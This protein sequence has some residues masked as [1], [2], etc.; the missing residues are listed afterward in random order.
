MELKIKRGQ[1]DA[2]LINTSMR[3]SVDARAVFTDEERK[4]IK[5][6]DLGKLLVY[7][8]EKAKAA[9]LGMQIVRDGTVKGDMRSI[10]LIAVAAMNI[11]IRVRDLEDGKSVE[12]KSLDEVLGAEEAFIEGCKN[13]QAYLDT[14]ATFDGRETIMSFTSAPR[15]DGGT[16]EAY[17]TSDRTAASLG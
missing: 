16:T 8:S 12:C 3:F 4:S 17:L 13:L 2:G 9:A 10:G 1:R 5:K 7:Q 6:Y 15:T 14:A 11:N